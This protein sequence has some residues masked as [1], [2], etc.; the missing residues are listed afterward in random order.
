ME[1]DLKSVLSKRSVPDG[2]CCQE[3]YYVKRSTSV[4]EPCPTNSVSKYSNLLCGKISCRVQSK[5]GTVTHFG[6]AS[7]LCP[8]R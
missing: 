4:C 6:G 1:S 8:G 7:A 2:S 3:N 5:I